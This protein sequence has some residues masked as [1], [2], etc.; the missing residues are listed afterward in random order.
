MREVSRASAR[1]DPAAR[2]GVCI[3]EWDWRFRVGFDRELRS[4]VR[5][6]VRRHRPES[7]AAIL[8]SILDWACGFVSLDALIA[9]LER[10][11]APERLLEGVEP[12]RLLPVPDALCDHVG[13]RVEGAAARLAPPLRARLQALFREARSGPTPPP[14]RSLFEITFGGDLPALLHAARASETPRRPRSEMLFRDEV[15]EFVDAALADLRS[16][17]AIVERFGPV[18]LAPYE[19]ELRE[20]WGFAEYWPVEMRPGA[21]RDLFIVLV[22][23]DGLHAG[24]LRVS[25]VHELYPGHGLFFERV[26]RHDV[27]LVD[28]GAMSLIEGWAT[29]CEW[30]TLKDAFSSFARSSR[31]SLLRYLDRGDPDAAGE[32]LGDLERQGYTSDLGRRAALY[33]YQYPGFS[34]SYSLGALWLERALE[35][36]RPLEFLEGAGDRSWGDFFLT[37]SR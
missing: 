14:H 5:D 1:P 29:F 32:I 4:R 36:R 18:D 10:G 37:W 34:F 31:L 28:Y 6:V 12:Q 26:R 25:L 13:Q 23:P 11:S 33:H 30:H 2:A 15:R 27:P 16:D 20:G 21:Q 35:G 24:D 22:N 17:P 19:F 9:E 3:P 7:E 8:G